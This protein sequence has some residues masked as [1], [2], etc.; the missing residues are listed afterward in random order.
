MTLK[1]RVDRILSRRPELNLARF[2]EL[3]GVGEASLNNAYVAEAGLQQ[4]SEKKWVRY[5]L[6]L[7]HIA[8]RYSVFIWHTTTYMRAAAYLAAEMGWNDETL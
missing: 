3:T 5:G 4:C 7:K 6:A 1:Q 2:V 8:S